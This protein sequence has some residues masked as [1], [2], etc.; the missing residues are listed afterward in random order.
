MQDFGEKEER[1]CE[2]VGGRALTESVC[3]VCVPVEE[4]L[5]SPSSPTSTVMTPP[6]ER[7]EMHR[8]LH[9]RREV[10]VNNDSRMSVSTPGR[11]R[12]GRDR[13]NDC[14]P[15]LVRKAPRVRRKRS[16]SFFDKI[17]GIAGRATAKSER[18]LGHRFEWL[19]YD[20]LNDTVNVHHSS[21]VNTALQMAYRKE[22]SITGG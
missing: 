2:L 22:K 5:E 15:C 21:L 1:Q 18:G 6:A 4:A 17:T 7:P 11:A 14:Q 13:S 16:S 10:V 20:Y 3:V 12:T 9:D 19:S 8:V